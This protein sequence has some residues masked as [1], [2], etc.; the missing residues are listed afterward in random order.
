MPELTLDTARNLAIVLV[1]VFV[2]GG[3]LSAWLIGKVVAKVIAIA[4]FAV[5]A[6]AVW[7]NREA[8]EDCADKVQTAFALGATPADRECNLFGFTVEIPAPDGG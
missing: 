6:V 5:L 3:F 4:V 8:L 1:I 7:A 2:I